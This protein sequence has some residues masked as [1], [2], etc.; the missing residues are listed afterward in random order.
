MRARAVQEEAEN[1]RKSSPGSSRRARG[2]T[3]GG[4]AGVG[5]ERLVGLRSKSSTS[6]IARLEWVW[7]VSGGAVL[8]CFGGGSG[9]GFGSGLGRPRNSLT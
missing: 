9:F 1:T 5:L 8:V 3:T 4:G 6:G 7:R 2:S